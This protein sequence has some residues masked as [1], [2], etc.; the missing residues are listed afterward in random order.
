[1]GDSNEASS[2]VFEGQLDQFRLALGRRARIS[3]EPNLVAAQPGTL[4]GPD[5]YQALPCRPKPPAADG[6]AP[7]N[8]K[9][10][11]TK[12]ESDESSDHDGLLTN[13]PGGDFAG[14]LSFCL[15]LRG[16]GVFEYV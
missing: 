13:V 3:L 14:G 10:R 6:D 4:G 8:K 16:R 1:M 12:G 7:A 11:T 2:K 5:F 15:A 9:A